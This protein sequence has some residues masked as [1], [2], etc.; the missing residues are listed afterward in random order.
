M[1][2][3][4]TGTGWDKI[5]AIF[6]GGGKPGPFA[7]Y[8]PA[9]AIAV[10][11]GFKAAGLLSQGAGG[12]EAA[13]RS[14]QA[15]E[16]QAQQL[17]INSGQALASSQRRAY[18]K[19][20]EG[21]RL[22]SAIKARAGAGGADPTVLN[23]IAQA[24]ASRAYAMQVERYEGKDTAR[25][26]NMKAAATRYQ[27]DL[28]VA[29]AK[30]AKRGYDFAAFGTLAEGASLFQKYWPT[31]KDNPLGGVSK[32]DEQ[33]GEDPFAYENDPSMWGG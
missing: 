27:A 21:Q 19:G 14:K 28:S 2:L 13:S 18:L 31:G 15:A 20:L 5:G 32:M 12:V 9:I 10:S 25:T 3:R 4:D 33:A 30:S 26:L 6:S 17:E 29:D 22:I 7:A 24:E 1:S 23:I 16:F 11:S 8:M